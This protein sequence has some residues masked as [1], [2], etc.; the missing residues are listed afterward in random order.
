M[1]SEIQRSFIAEFHTGATLLRCP[2]KKL[3]RRFTFVVVA[4]DEDSEVLLNRWRVVDGA[5]Q[6]SS[7]VLEF[8]RSFVR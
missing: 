5:P 2:F 8:W 4:A 6:S 1:G 7:K 3:T